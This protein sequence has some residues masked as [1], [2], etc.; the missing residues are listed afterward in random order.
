MQPQRHLLKLAEV[1]KV[2]LSWLQKGDGAFYPTLADELK[3]Q[4]LIQRLVGLVA[5]VKEQAKKLNLSDPHDLSAQDLLEAPY[6]SRQAPLDSRTRDKM[7]RDL[8]QLQLTV[9]ELKTFFH[10]AAYDLPED[11]SVTLHG[12]M[13]YVLSAPG[14][15]FKRPRNPRPSGRQGAGTRGGSS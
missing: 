6:C 8:E 2:Q 11:I 14:Y 5:E 10:S 7:W 1:L 9:G 13:G 15:K 12:R 3:I 4:G